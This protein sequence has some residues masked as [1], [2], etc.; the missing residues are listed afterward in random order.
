MLV[1]EEADAGTIKIGETVELSYVD[2]SR[3]SLDPDKTVWRSPAA[4]S[5]S[6]SAP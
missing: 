4:S 6:R 1:G 2:Q 5:T 3:D